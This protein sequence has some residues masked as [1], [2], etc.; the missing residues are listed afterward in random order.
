MQGQ[1]KMMSFY[2]KIHSAAEGMSLGPRDYMAYPTCPTPCCLLLL[3][4]PPR[5]STSSG[6]SSSQEPAVPW[7]LENAQTHFHLAQRGK[8][9]FWAFPQGVPG[10]A[11]ITASILG[12]S[13]RQ[14]L[15]TLPRAPWA[16]RQLLAGHMC[17]RSPAS[18]AQQV[19]FSWFPLIAYRAFAIFV[20]FH[21]HLGL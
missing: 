21:V 3:H 1:M 14:K 4:L 17:C 19:T 15:S 7:E 16:D 2:N 6:C 20:A 13:Q 8:A 12:R 18:Q 11:H 5:G 9:E 10:F